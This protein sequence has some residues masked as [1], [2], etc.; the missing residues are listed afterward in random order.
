[1]TAGATAVII[2]GRTWTGTCINLPGEV[3]IAVASLLV[4][5]A[6]A[7]LDYGLVQAGAPVALL[8]NELRVAHG[9]ELDGEC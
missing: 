8:V 6:A 9:G 7:T 3:A 2:M 4:V 1:M 5:D